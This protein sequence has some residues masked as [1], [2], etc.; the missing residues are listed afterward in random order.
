MLI[1]S[2]ELTPH[3][4]RHE[5]DE[6]KIKFLP[7]DFNNNFP[8]KKYMSCLFLYN[9]FKL[10][11]TIYCYSS[12]C[13]IQMNGFEGK[14]KKPHHQIN[15][16]IKQEADEAANPNKEIDQ[17]GSSSSNNKCCASCHLTIDDKYIFNLMDTYWHGECLQCSQCGHLLQQTCFFKNGLLFCKDDYLK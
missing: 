17:N 7:K 16:K 15:E 12:Q 11:F 2:T 4:H 3:R 13:F 14:H 6:D 9:N 8:N 1:N 10:M 5:D